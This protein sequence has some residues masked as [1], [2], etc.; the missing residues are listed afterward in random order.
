MPWCLV[1]SN[2]VVNHC[3]CVVV[4]LHLYSAQ[5][6]HVRWWYED[7]EAPK[8]NTTTGYKSDGPSC[9]GALQMAH[10]LPINRHLILLENLIYSLSNLYYLFHHS[11]F[12]SIVKPLNKVVG[13][14][15]SFILSLSRALHLI[16]GVFNFFPLISLGLIYRVYCISNEHVAGLHSLGVGDRQN[17]KC[18]Y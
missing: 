8:Q 17:W 13:T 7:E 11:L 4:L 14:L 3:I 10:S 9:T 16:W 18:C 5:C 2:C 12:K 6:A 1:M 15:I